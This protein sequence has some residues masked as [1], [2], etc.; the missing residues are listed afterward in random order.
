MLVLLFIV[1]KNKARVSS[2]TV[3]TP[4]W[5][6][7]VYMSGLYQGLIF[8]IV[9]LQ[10]L[11]LLTSYHIKD[12]E[13]SNM[14]NVQM[15]VSKIHVIQLPKKSLI[16]HIRPSVNN[17]IL[18][19]SPDFSGNLRAQKPNK[20]QTKGADII[21]VQYLRAYHQMVSTSSFILYP[22]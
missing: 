9:Q 10:Y 8:P 4:M 6:N 16:L 18:G 7:L 19:F 15:Y 21:V 13:S 5:D 12:P 22:L 1:D 3:C 17:K 14:E 20:A 2:Y 11:K